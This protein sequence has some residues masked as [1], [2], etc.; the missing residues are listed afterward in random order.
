VIRVRKYAYRTEQTYLEWLARFEKFVHGRDLAQCG[1]EEVRAFLDDLAVQGKVTA[2]TQR[3]ALNALVFFYREVL[4]RD[5]G[6]FSDYRRASARTSLRTSMTRAECER[7]LAEVEGSMRLV[8]GV[9][10]GSGMRLMECLRLRVKD[11]DVERRTITVRQGKGG[12]D[13]ITM[14]PERF[15][16]L[17][18]THLKAIRSTWEQDRRAGLAGVWMPEALARKYPKA[19]VA[20]EWFWVWPSREIS[21]DPRGWCG[22]IMPWT[23]VCSAPSSKP[24]CWPISRRRL[25]VTR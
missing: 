12:K 18:E 24:H 14:L 20:W 8:V 13:R 7:F 23:A 10:Y 25:V 5:L 15:M 19:G 17:L 4:D 6:D 3:Q 22:G 21:T 2:S 9:L 16:P 1:V 11:L